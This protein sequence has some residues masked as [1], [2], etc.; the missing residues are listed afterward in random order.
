MGAIGNSLKEQEPLET[1][2]TPLKQQES[3]GSRIDSK[4][5]PSPGRDK[6]PLGSSSDPLE[7]ARIP[8]NLQGSPRNILVLMEGLQNPRKAAE[9]LWK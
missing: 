6:G 9:T 7:V 5:K 1:T 4:E 8:W 3:P 2:G